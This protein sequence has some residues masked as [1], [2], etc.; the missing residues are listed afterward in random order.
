MT[1]YLPDTSRVPA[2][3]M[4]LRNGED[5]VETLKDNVVKVQNQMKQ[6]VDQ[7]C[8]ECIFEMGDMVFLKLQP[9]K[10]KSIADKGSQ[11]LTP[12]C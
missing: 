3:E 2:V 9:D 8:R 6:H 10:Q 5:I 11:R 12:K 1:L 7:H 4:A